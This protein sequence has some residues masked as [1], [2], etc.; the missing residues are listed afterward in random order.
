MVKGR[1]TLAVSECYMIP[2]TRIEEDGD[3]VSIQILDLLV[4]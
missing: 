4:F 2:K 3:D 1:D